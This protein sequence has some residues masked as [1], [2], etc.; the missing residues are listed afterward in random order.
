MAQRKATP[1]AKRSSRKKAAVAS[2]RAPENALD[3]QALFEQ[4]PD[5]LLVLLPDAPRLTMVAATRSRFAATGTDVDSL[6]KGLFEVFPDNPDDPS[7]TGT[8]NL[9]ASL[10]RALKTR[11]PDTMAV[12]KYDVRDA[13]GSFVSRYWSPRNIPVLSADGEVRYLLHRVEEVTDLEHQSERGEEL[14]D[15]NNAMKGEVIARS[16]ELSAA[17]DDIRKANT[18]LGELDQAKTADRKSVV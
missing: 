1:K 4:S 17:I 6:G 8:S 12:Q 5:I 7:A 3:F 14:R 10:E 15:Q 13:D 11:A 16:R 2:S 18:A 9:R